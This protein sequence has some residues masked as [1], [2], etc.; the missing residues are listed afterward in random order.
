LLS[1]EQRVLNGRLGAAVQQSRHNPSDYTAKARA[2]FLAK[3]EDEVDPNR[4]LPEAERARRAEVA[5]RAH[6]LRMS[7][8]SA[9]KRRARD[10]RKAAEDAALAARLAELEAAEA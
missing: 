6:F 7:L 9:A 8:R 3:F 2:T 1:P 4:E 10:E 5:K